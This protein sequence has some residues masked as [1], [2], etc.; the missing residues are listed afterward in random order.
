MPIIVIISYVIVMNTRYMLFELTRSL[1]E[2][3]V[4]LRRDERVGQFAQQFL[5]SAGQ[6]VSFES[7]QVTVAVMICEST[8]SME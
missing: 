4:P 5:E 3:V 8:K 6:D 2:S 1:D 7:G